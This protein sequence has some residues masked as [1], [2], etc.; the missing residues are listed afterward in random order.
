MAWTFYDF[1]DERG[2]NGIRAA[3]DALPPS[4]RARS[5]AALTQRLNLLKAL[6]SLQDDQ[7]TKALS[8]ACDGLFEIRFRKDGVQ[9]R[10]LAFYG[11]GRREITLLLLAEERNG[12]FVP[13][14]ACAT[15]LRRRGLALQDRRFIQPHDY[16]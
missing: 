14:D 3:L 11:P 8:G 5:K 4:R 1:V 9:Y 7:Y 16:R 15:A 13:R 10:P 2:G 6:P 12:R